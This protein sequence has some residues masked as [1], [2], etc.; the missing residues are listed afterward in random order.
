VLSA[1]ADPAPGLSARVALALLRAYKIAISPLF[2]GSCRFLPSCSDYARDAVLEYGALKGS[3][4]AAR[5]LARC[6]PFAAAGHDPVPRRDAAVDHHSCR[7]SG[8]A[9]PVLKA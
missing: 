5:R 1:D 6:H 2:A 4:L 3:W 8:P 7:P 9:S